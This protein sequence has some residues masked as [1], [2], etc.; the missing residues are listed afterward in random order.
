MSSIAVFVAGT[1]S[2]VVMLLIALAFGEASAGI[3]ASQPEIWKPM[4]S[5][6]YIGMIFLY[7]LIGLVYALV[8]SVLGKGIKGRALDK[9]L[10]FGG[11]AWFIGPLPYVLL[12]HVTIAADTALIVL[13]LLQGLLNSLAGGLTAALVFEMI[14][15]GIKNGNKSV[16]SGRKRAGKA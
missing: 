11:L 10:L 8:Y 12:I 2:A 15:R 5:L 13:W 3:Y 16:R 9:G 14:D 6:W 7:L 1:V 4:T